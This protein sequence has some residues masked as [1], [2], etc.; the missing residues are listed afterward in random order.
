MKTNNKRFIGRFFSALKIFK[1]TTNY[2]LS[3]RLTE[4]MK[5]LATGLTRRYRFYYKHYFLFHLKDLSQ[6]TSV[7]EVFEDKIY[8]L[9][10]SN[11]LPTIVDIGAAIGDST[12]FFIQKYPKAKLYAYESQKSLFKLLRENINHNIFDNSNISLVNKMVVK[13]SNNKDQIEFRNILDSIDGKIDLLKIDIEGGEYELIDDILI[14]SKKILKLAVELHYFE[15]SSD[16][17]EM[18]NF[19]SNLSKKYLIYIATPWYNSWNKGVF[20]IEQMF[21]ESGPKNYYVMLY[22]QKI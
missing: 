22:C 19:I 21:P 8:N 16:R 17:Q 6:I 2:K 4:I 10:L 7:K 15:N 18:A 20:D 9:R 1:K 11:P 13:K 12:L 3:I 5:F 14:S